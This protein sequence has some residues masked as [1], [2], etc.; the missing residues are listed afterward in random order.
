[1]LLFTVGL[2]GGS[3]FPPEI[4]GKIWSQGRRHH[5]RH[6]VDTDQCFRLSRL[7]HVF[8]RRVFRPIRNNFPR[9]DGRPTAVIIYMYLLFQPPPPCTVFSP[10]SSL[11]RNITGGGT[12]QILLLH[13]LYTYLDIGTRCRLSYVSSVSNPYDVQYF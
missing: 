7:G 12:V 1:V 3:V 2:G 10:T 8:P 5:R 13:T 11:L 9:P 6:P 4:E